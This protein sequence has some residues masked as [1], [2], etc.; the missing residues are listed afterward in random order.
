[1][2]NQKHSSKIKNEKIERWRL[3]L[4]SFKFE[5]I[6]RP[7]KDNTVADAL[8]RVCAHINFDNSKLKE[9]HE[10]LCHPGVTRLAH[11]VRTKNLPYSINDIKL[12]TTSCR[13]CA[14]IKPRFNKNK[15]QL[16][17]ATSPFER[18]NIDFKGPLPSNTQNKYMLTIIDEYSRFPFAYPCKDMTATTVIKCLKDLFFMFGTPLYVHS[19]RGATFMSEQLKHFFYSLGIACSRTTPYNPQGNGQ[20]EKLNGTLWR[21]IQLYLRSKDMEISDWEKALPV[22]LHSI[23]SLLCTNTNVTP[24]ERMFNHARGTSNGESFPSWMLNPGPVLMKKNVRAT[25]YDPIVEEVELLQPNPQYSY[26]R[27]SDGRETTISNRQLVPLPENLEDCNENNKMQ[28]SENIQD[29]NPIPNQKSIE[30][31]Q[32]HELPSTSSSFKERRSTRQRRIPSYLNDYSSNEKPTR[33]VTLPKGC[34]ELGGESRGS[35]ES[36]NSLCAIVASL[37]E[38]MC[39][40]VLSRQQASAGRSGADHSVPLRASARLSPPLAASRRLSPATLS[41]SSLRAR[42][43]PDRLDRLDRA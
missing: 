13:V 20:V 27:L 22:A 26:V 34:F 19:D 14:E 23:R 29:E 6:Y 37:A 41:D 33:D 38:E 31:N 15:Y 9:I 2:F 43:A 39:C 12:I 24:H 3:E 7:G 32:S 25:K 8:S 4:S 36:P 10:L 5:I 16:I 40:R 21:N 11:W 42:P 30:N 18:L 28:N 35:R 17:K 1:M